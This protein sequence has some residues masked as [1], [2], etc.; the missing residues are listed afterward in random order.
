MILQEISSSIFEPYDSKE[1]IPK[2]ISFYVEI[3][4]YFFQMDRH[5]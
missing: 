4:F 3:L 2:E 1:Y 5:S